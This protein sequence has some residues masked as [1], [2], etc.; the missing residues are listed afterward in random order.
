MIIADLPQS[1]RGS[2]KGFFP[3]GFAEMGKRVR[4]INV[5]DGVL[6]RIVLADQRDSQ[7]VRMVR[8]IES[9]ATFNAEPVFVG[10]TVATGHV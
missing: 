9:E 5:F 2:F 7:T 1:T 6:R 10:G 4:R 3:T 8:V